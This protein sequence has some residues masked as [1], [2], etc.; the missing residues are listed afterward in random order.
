M[1]NI[2]K[3]IDIPNGQG[4][5]AYESTVRYMRRVKKSRQIRT[6]MYGK[7]DSQFFL[8]YYYCFIIFTNSS[9]MCERV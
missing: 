9:I 3:F 1:Y 5:C 6:S 2:M 7:Y 4:H 8:Y